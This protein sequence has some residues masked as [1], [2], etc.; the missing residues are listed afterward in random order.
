M[1]Q[2]FE[3]VAWVLYGR[4]LAIGMSLHS[5]Q[6]RKGRRRWGKIGFTNIDPKLISEVEEAIKTLLPDPRSNSPHP[7][8]QGGW[9]GFTP[10]SLV[11]KN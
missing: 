6:V 9:N 1:D 8:V 2:T 3:T 4:A 10:A 11:R 7:S 5:T